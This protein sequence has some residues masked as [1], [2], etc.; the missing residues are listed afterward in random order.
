MVWM[1]GQSWCLAV[2]QGFETPY[3]PDDAGNLLHLIQ[4][5][6]I[7]LGA[8]RSSD[9]PTFINISILPDFFKIIPDAVGHT[10]SLSDASS[11]A[12]HLNFIDVM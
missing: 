11:F 5:L 3:S 9:R 4:S 8:Y 12:E 7:A 1:V 2:T 6:R 10:L